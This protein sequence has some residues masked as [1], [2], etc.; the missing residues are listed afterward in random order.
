MT[1]LLPIGEFSRMTYL[2]VKALRH[3]HDLGLLEPADID[4]ASGYRLYSTDQVPTALLISRFRDLEMPLDQ[5]RAML[6]A[7]DLEARNQVILAHLERMEQRLERTQSTVASLK[8][9]LELRLP[10]DVEHRVIPDLRVLAITELVASADCEAWLA[11]AFGELAATLAALRVQPAGAPSTIYAN[12]FFE[13]SEGELVAYVALPDGAPAL[14]GTLLPGRRARH[15]DRWRRLRRC[16]ARRLVR[17]SRPDIRRAR[18]VRE[19]ARPRG[20]RS[21]PRALPDPRQRQSQPPAHGGVLADESRS[22]PHMSNTLIALTFDCADAATLASFW[23]GVLG[24]PVDDGGN[25][26]F[27]SIGYAD[28]P[29]HAAWFFIKVPESKAAK[30]RFHPDLITSSDLAAEAARV[31]ALGA[32]QHG[33]FNEGG[34]TWITFADPEGNEFDIVAG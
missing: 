10:L 9:L 29:K 20:R 3:Y 12:E 21:H 34:H 18:H 19:R 30:N 33:T 25:A 1:V 2:T 14:E 31:V 5:V 17:R 27:S 22:N 23:S 13:E 15:D 6:D 4:P 7:A 28:A 16:P 32:T 11:R 26:D 8:S 24:Q